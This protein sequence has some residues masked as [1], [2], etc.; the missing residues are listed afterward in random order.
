MNHHVLYICVR[1]RVR[2]VYAEFYL[3]KQL[4]E[5]LGPIAEEIKISS[6]GFYPKILR[7]IL[8]E[9]KISAPEPFFYTNMSSVVRELLRKN[10][11][12]VPDGW[13]SKPLTPDLITTA[14]VV[15]TALSWQKEEIAGEFP[16]V[17]DKIFTFR[18]M[19]AWD[20]DILFETITGLP[21][22]ESFWDFC[23]ENPPYVTKVIGEVEELMNRGF[24]CMLKNLG[25]E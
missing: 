13:R 22:D 8:D 7:D 23:E 21:M 16:E 3:R 2:S 4:I 10:E 6:A 17:R 9:A 15:V 14:D 19:A 20:D 1:N 25:F 24:P 12:P 11:M 18:E 5:K